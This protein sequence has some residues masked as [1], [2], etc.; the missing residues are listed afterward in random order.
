MRDTAMTVLYK[1]FN[2]VRVGQH[3]VAL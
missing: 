3:D 2:I 1:C